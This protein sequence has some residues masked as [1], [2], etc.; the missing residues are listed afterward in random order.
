MP[1]GLRFV[2][3][4]QEYRNLF[5]ASCTIDLFP[6]VAKVGPENWLC[7]N[8]E[9]EAFE[10]GL[11]AASLGQITKEHRQESGTAYLIEGPSTWLKVVVA[12][13]GTQKGL[14]NAWVETSVLKKP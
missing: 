12:D 11:S 9:L 5:S 6:A 4:Y 10:A 14:L 3:F 2:L 8:A 7:S 13:G 1:S